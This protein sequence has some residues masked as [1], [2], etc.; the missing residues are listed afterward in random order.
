MPQQARWSLAFRRST[1]HSPSRAQV[2]GRRSSSAA[3][4]VVAFLQTVARSRLATSRV[5]RE[6]IE[7]NFAASTAV[8]G[9]YC[10]LSRFFLAALGLAALLHVL[11]FTSACLATPPSSLP[12]IGRLCWLVGFARSSSSLYWLAWRSL[13]PSCQV[14]WL[15]AAP[16][17]LCPC[18][19]RRQRPGTAASGL[20]Q[21]ADFSGLF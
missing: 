14:G 12:S 2:L 8:L 4:R 13:T 15:G 11:L 10:C 16:C 18:L 5:R 19:G 6:F 7:I 3:T 1:Q 21:L 20:S 9:K 17:H